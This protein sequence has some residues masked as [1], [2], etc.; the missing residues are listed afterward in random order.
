MEASTV[1]PEQQRIKIAEVCGWKEGTTGLWQ[2]P[3]KSGYYACPD[4]LSDLNA[5]H[6]AE[7]VLDEQQKWNYGQLLA[8]LVLKDKNVFFGEE[9][10]PE[11]RLNGYGHFYLATIPAAQR[12][13]AFLRTLGLWQDK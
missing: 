10:D 13:E 11:P 3:D 6:E 5:M 9:A 8:S 12:A 2:D 7:K 4:Y 1:S